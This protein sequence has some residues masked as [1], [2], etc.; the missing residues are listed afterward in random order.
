MR[1][2]L[3]LLE[4]R[5]ELG[6]QAIQLPNDFICPLTLEKMKDPVVASDGRTYE[7]LAIM[8][9][10][11]KSRGPALSPFSREP[12]QPHLF[13]NVNLRSRIAEHAN[14]LLQAAELSRAAINNAT[15]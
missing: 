15:S 3:S 1:Q 14:E 13:A 5:R 10:M 12:L 11:R 7:R 9:L 6:L 4:R 2:K 8:E